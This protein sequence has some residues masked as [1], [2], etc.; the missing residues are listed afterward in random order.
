MGKYKGNRNRDVPQTESMPM[1]SEKTCCVLRARK[2]KTLFPT[3]KKYRGAG[4]LFDRSTPCTKS[5]PHPVTKVT[6]PHSLCE[7]FIG[8]I[9]IYVVWLV[10]WF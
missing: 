1:A 7:T 6:D 9:I 5:A 3:R 4:V 2:W 8:D 10:A